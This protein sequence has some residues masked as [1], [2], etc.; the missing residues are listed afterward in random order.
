MTP[1]IDQNSSYESLKSQILQKQE[2][3][4][5]VQESKAGELHVRKPSGNS[6]EMGQ[7]SQGERNADGAPESKRQGFRFS[8]GEASWDI[9]DDAELEFIADKKPMKMTLREMRDAAAGGVAVRNRMRQLAEEKKSL[10]DPYKDFSKS[11][12]EDPFNALKKVFSAV[13]KVDPDANFNEFISELGKQAESLSQMEPSA[14]KAHMLEKELE[15]TKAQVTDAQR[16]N[17]LGELKQELAEQTGL[18]D[19][20]IFH[21]GQEILNNPVLAKTVKNEED[22]IERIGDLALEVE[23]QQASHKALRK[24]KSDI[25]PRDPLVFELSSLL[26]EN[27]DFDDRDLEEIAHSVLGTVQKAKAS[28]NLSR[29]QN[30]N[31]VGS[32]ND[33]EPDFSRMSSFEALKYQIEMKKK[34]KIG[35]S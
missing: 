17:R 18:P 28:Q 30:R 24:Y 11:Y 20:K 25:S 9:D 2:E 34:Q 32:R 5:A 21:F 13:K 35:K 7:G 31:F 27:P 1:V 22:L 19:E 10:H 23:M 33:A 16:L 8:K 26:K 29:K 3:K 14:R 12:K 15:E 6:Q 4:H